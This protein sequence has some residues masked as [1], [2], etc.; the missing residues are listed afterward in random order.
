MEKKLANY[1]QQLKRTH[2]GIVSLQEILKYILETKNVDYYDARNDIR[3]E[4]KMLLDIQPSWLDIEDDQ[5]IFDK[6]LKEIPK[7]I[8][9][10]QQIKYGK[11]RI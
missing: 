11:E 7:D 5:G 2:A 10:T 1:I 3:E 9:K 4:Y 6:L 8:S